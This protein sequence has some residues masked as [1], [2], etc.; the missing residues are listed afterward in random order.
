MALYHLWNVVAEA[1][2]RTFSSQVLT[3]RL[4]IVG[5]MSPPF[6]PSSIGNLLS[7]LSQ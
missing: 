1:V 7:I 3:L 5:S 6:D 2:N 4:E